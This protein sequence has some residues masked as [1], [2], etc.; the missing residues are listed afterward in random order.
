MVGERGEAVLP[1]DLVELP[2]RFLEDVRVVDEREEKLGEGDGGL[3]VR[4][5]S[6]SACR[7]Y[8]RA[9]DILYHDRLQRG[10]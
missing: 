1:D 10:S 6:G 2:L 5:V 8:L 4:A 9:D 3:R 7:G